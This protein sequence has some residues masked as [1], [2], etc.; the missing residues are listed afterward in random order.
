M[1]GFQNVP[2][3]RERPDLQSLIYSAMRGEMA[4]Q[5][6]ALEQAIASCVSALAKLIAEMPTRDAI[7]M[8]GAIHQTL[9][10]RVA[11]FR[12]ATRGEVD[13]PPPNP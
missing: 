5:G 10:G 2:Q 12:M 3:D 9:A 6:I 4:A 11:K 13:G 8:M 7:A 1:G